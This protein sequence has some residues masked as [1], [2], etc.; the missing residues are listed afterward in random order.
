VVKELADIKGYLQNISNIATPTGLSLSVSTTRNL[1][2]TFGL[3]PITTKFLA[4]R[5]S[6]DELM[7]IL[8]IDHKLAHRLYMLFTHRHGNSLNEV[9]GI[10]DDII[11][12]I[13]QNLIISED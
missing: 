9:E 4:Q 1:G 5:C 3:N 13:Q 10:T 6:R 2:E 12:K 11:L 7:E 8:G